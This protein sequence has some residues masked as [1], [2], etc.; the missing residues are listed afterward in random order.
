MNVRIEKLP[1][2]VPRLFP[3]VDEQ[4]PPGGV[5]GLPGIAAAALIPKLL[6]LCSE[7]LIIDGDSPYPPDARVKLNTEK[8]RSHGIDEH[9]LHY[10]NG[11]VAGL[12]RLTAERLLAIDAEQG[13]HQVHA[14]IAFLVGYKVGTTINGDDYSIEY[15]VHWYGTK[16][17]LSKALTQKLAALIAVGS[18]AA[19]VIAELVALG[20]ITSP[21]AIPFGLVAAL[22]AL[23][24]AALILLDMC[25]GV[26]VICPNTYPPVF[27]PLPG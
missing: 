8:L 7:H 21:G 22:L 4:W 27:I 12:N 25:N 16:W 24:S 15:S 23:G 11:I 6:Q 17:H 10:L 9:D 3:R 20:I 2:P 19:W 26:D 18:G 5:G 13:W 1:C 14:N